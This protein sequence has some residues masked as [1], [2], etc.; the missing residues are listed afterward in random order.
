MWTGLICASSERRR[1]DGTHGPWRP[2]AGTF[3]GWPRAAAKVSPCSI[4][5]WDRG[6]SLSSPLPI[7]VA[8]RMAEEGLNERGGYRCGATGQSVRAGDR[9]TLHANRGVQ[10][11]FCGMARSGFHALPQLNLACS[12]LAIGVTKAEWLKLAEK[13]VVAADPA[14]KRDLL[15]IEKN[16]LTLGLEERVKNGLEALY[17][18][19]AKAPWLGSLIDPRRASADIFREGFDK[20]QPLLT[21]I[22]AAADTDDVREMAVAAQGM[23]KAAELTSRKYTLVSTNVPYL[24]RNKQHPIIAEYVDKSAPNS[25]PDLYATFFL[26]CLDLSLDGGACCIVSPQA[27]FFQKSFLPLRKFITNNTS[28]SI[29]VDLGRAAFDDMNWWAATTALTITKTATPTAD[30]CYCTLDASTN[31]GSQSKSTNVHDKKLVCVPQQRLNSSVDHLIF[32]DAP[33]HAQKKLGDYAQV[34]QGIS[35]TDLPRF[36]L[37]FWEKDVVDEDWDYYQLAPTDELSGFS[38]GTDI[39]RWGRGAGDLARIQTAHKGLKAQGRVG[40]G[41]A[42]N[43]SLRVTRFLGTRFDGTIAVLLPYSSED[44]LAINA[45][46]TD[47]SFKAEVKKIDQALSV[48][49]ASFLKVPFDCNHWS[50]VALARF[51]NGIP[52]ASTNDLTQWIFDGRPR[53]A[54]KPL[55][56]ATAFSH[57]IP[58]ASP[59]WLRFRRMPNGWYGRP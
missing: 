3:D 35:T 43:N 29:V 33:D 31:K 27:W 40:W 17:D 21:S 55:H 2:A 12:G 11:R 1:K 22:L 56:V 20:L 13:A 25:R 45:F 30:S 52:S 54:A 19:F 48:T 18:L 46:V 36:T 16:L 5:A 41:V 26:R 4:P 6:T 59:D 58:M 23:A 14:A 51:P 44:A 9:P 50:E 34:F 15:G 57:G 7:L 32:V 38:G 28:L 39:L 37:S 10:S 49:E 24:G 8:F 47:P 53:T 42:V